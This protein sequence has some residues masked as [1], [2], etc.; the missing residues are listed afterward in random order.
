LSYYCHSKH[1]NLAKKKL[2]PLHGKIITV[3]LLEVE[4]RKAW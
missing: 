3:H 1:C 2:K 4:C